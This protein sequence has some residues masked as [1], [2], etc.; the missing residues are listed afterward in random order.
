MTTRAAEREPREEAAM[1]LVA[2][3]TGFVGA[4]IVREL[5]RRRESVRVMSRD[6]QAARRRFQ[7]LP[8]ESVAGDVRR[9]DTVA[10]A[11]AGCDTVISSLAF[12]NLPIEDKRKGYTFVEID[13]EGSK[14]VLEAAQAAGAK[15]FVYMSAV[16]AAP[17]GRYHWFRAKAEAERAVRESGVGYVIWRPTWVYGPEDKALN[18]FAGFALRL[19]F[20]PVIGSGKQQMQPV[21]IDDVGRAV[22]DGLATAAA[23]GRTIEIGGPEVMS[24]NEVLRTMLRVMGKRRLM[25]HTPVPVMK[26]VAA[27]MAPLPNRPLTPDAVDFIAMDAVADN[28]FLIETLKPQL[29]PLADG[30]ATYLGPKS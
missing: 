5:V 18:R 6:P 27:L 25:L 24:M 20:L 10:A 29:T 7:G 15:T 13:Q 4:G 14:R 8:V 3:G 22:C 26:L 21:F 2:G 9:P 19:P 1:I 16:G 28:T 30:L 17:D 12:P 11:V 23:R